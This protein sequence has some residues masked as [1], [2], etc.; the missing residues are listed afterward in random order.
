MVDAF[1]G[2]WLNAV[3]LPDETNPY[4][5]PQAELRVE[6]QV[7]DY[8]YP[9]A[10]GG[11]RFVN[12]I[13]DRICSYGMI[14]AIGLGLGVLEE[15]GV[16][17]GVLEWMGE[18]NT[19]ADYLLTGLIVCFY[20]ILMEGLFGRTIG[21]MITGTKVIGLNGLH[22]GWG[23]II[24]R[25]LARLVPF[26]PFSFLGSEGNGWHDR[27]TDTRVIDVRAKPED[28]RYQKPAWMKRR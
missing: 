10:S 25:S 19:V 11:K 9:D 15:A 24:L 23:T 13:I 2:I 3:M 12:Y 4:A 20:Y 18:L 1:D 17:S 22:P 16:V 28:A 21:K 8:A 27:W 7:H 5:A 6:D 26:E 14:F